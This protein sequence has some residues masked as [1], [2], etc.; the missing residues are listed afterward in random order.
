M[1]SCLPAKVVGNNG[2]LTT[3]TYDA[4]GNV[5]T[6][7]DAA[8]RVTTMSYDALDRPLTQTNPDLGVTLYGYHPAGWL[9]TVT[10]AESQTT[11]YEY[12]GFGDLTHGRRAGVLTR[13][14][15]AVPDQG[16]EADPAGSARGG[17]SPGKPTNVYLT[18]LTP[19]AAHIEGLILR[20]AAPGS[21]GTPT[22]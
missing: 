10:D 13:A 1:C 7:T 16:D 9:A 18:E 21:P 20:L 19:R 4:K 11:S 15:D 22:K 5:R 8:G 14:H 6:I 12:N 17:V 2:Q 3:F